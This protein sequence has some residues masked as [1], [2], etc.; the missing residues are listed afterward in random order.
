MKKDLLVSSA[1]KGLWIA[2]SRMKLWTDTGQLLALTATQ[3]SAPVA[4]SSN[5]CPFS[6]RP[7]GAVFAF[8]IGPGRMKMQDRPMASPIIS[9]D[10]FHGKTVP[11]GSRTVSKTV[12]G[13][14]GLL[15]KKD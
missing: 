14:G 12:F 10:D 3:H 2:S 11:W 8:G 1:P 6:I 5:C 15:S 9:G 13:Q 4:P 7:A